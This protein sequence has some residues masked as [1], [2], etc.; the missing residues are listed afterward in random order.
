MNMISSFNEIG[1]LADTISG[2]KKLAEMRQAADT[3]QAK[4]AKTRKACADFEA[5][6]LQQLL[7]TMRESVPDGG[8]FA[9]GYAKDMYESM[10]DEALAKHLAE[11]QGMGFGE[12]LYK[13]LSGQ[14][15]ATAGL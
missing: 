5:L 13:Q 6:M 10:H 7:K 4:D 12:V 11:G 9:G 1:V 15:R 2:S 3:D 8:L 14:S